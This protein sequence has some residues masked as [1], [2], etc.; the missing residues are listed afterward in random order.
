[1]KALAEILRGNNFLSPQ[2][3]TKVMSAYRKSESAQDADAMESCFDLLSNREREILKLIA[4]GN[5]NRDIA[6]LLF[7]SDQTV[8]AHRAS[9]MKKLGLKNIAEMVR[10]AIKEGLIEP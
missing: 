3:T 5:S 8:K 1:M 7:I 10:Y 4:E 9:I 2:I 6:A